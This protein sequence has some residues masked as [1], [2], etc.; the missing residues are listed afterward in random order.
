LAKLKLTW[1]K[2]KRGEEDTKDREKDELCFLMETGTGFW[3][4]TS[5]QLIPTQT[6]Y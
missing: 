2:V 5:L 4:P 6:G 1:A 3:S